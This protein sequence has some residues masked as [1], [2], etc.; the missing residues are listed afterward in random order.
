MTLLSDLASDIA[1][2]HVFFD[3]DSGFAVD[4]TYQGS[5]LR[6]IFDNEYAE[7]EAGGTPIVGSQ[8]RARCRTSEAP[9]VGN[10][11]QIGSDW[12]VVRNVE[13]TGHGDS[14]VVLHEGVAES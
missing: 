14:V 11:L 8:P 7:F 1:G 2:E 10:S 9:T 12:Y 5:D 4:A 6:L 13:D 3:E